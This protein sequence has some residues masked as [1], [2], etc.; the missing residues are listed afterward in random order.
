VF[1][2]GGWRVW[3]EDETRV[4]LYGGGDGGGG[5]EVEVVAFVCWAEAARWK[6][7][8]RIKVLKKAGVGGGDGGPEV[9]GGARVSL[10][11]CCFCWSFMV[12][13]PLAFEVE[14]I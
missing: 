10:R 2:G 9:A 13:T 12:W 14:R 6:G 1:G 7:F 11:D 8:R 4:H 5:G 3:E